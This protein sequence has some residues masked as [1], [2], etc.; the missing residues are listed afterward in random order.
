MLLK[1]VTGSG[2]RRTRNRERVLNF[3]KVKV[4]LNLNF[5]TSRVLLCSSKDY[6][7]TSVIARA[8]MRVLKCITVVFKCDARTNVKTVM[9]SNEC[10]MYS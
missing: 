3:R 7:V 5:A 9:A 8:K 1:L 2:E 6:I 10:A 4:A